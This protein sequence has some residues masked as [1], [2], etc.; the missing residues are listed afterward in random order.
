M[1][2]RSPSATR[3]STPDTTAESQRF[4]RSGAATRLGA[5]PLL[6]V[7]GVLA[8][9]IGAIAHVVV[10]IVA[11]LHIRVDGPRRFAAEEVP[12]MAEGLAWL[13]ALSAWSG[14]VIDR[15]PSA[16]AGA[17]LT[18]ILE[19]PPRPRAARALARWVTGLPGALAIAILGLALLPLWL[20]GL[21][22]LAAR[23][24]PPT[25]VRRA[26]LAAIRLQARYLARLASMSFLAVLVPPGARCAGGGDA[27]TLPSDLTC[28]WAARPRT[29]RP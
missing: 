29:P 22:M 13:L 20:A 28:R 2:R 5:L 18:L 11:A 1:S 10:P 9:W 21:A 23:G 3:H 27:L 4:S 8:P 24:S 15:F 25:S 7:A 26:H 19:A 17:S 14:M 12:R 16:R 6:G